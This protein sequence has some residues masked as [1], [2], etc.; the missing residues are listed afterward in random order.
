MMSR[1]QITIIGLGL[2]GGSLAKSLNKKKSSY[3]THAYARSASTLQKAEK[4]GDIT[5]G[6]TNIGEAVKQSDIIIFCTPLST[7]EQLLKEALPYLKEGVIITDA[8]SAKQS[9]IDILSPLLTKAQLKNFV[10]A[11]PIAGA[12]KSGYSAAKKTLF[13]DK[14]LFMTPAPTTTVA[15]MDEVRNLWKQAGANVDELPPKRHDAIYATVSHVPQLLAFAYGHALKALDEQTQY[16][17]KQNESKGYQRFRR[18]GDSSTAMWND[19]FAANQIAIGHALD[20]VLDALSLSVQH[21]DE[22]TQDFAR[23]HASLYVLEH[24][25]LIDEISPKAFVYLNVLPVMLSRALHSVAE[26]YLPY[27]GTG[28]ADFTAMHQIPL[29]PKE[30]ASLKK[31]ILEEVAILKE[32]LFSIGHSI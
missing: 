22:R 4:A 12:E 26:L 13:K 23:N 15:A 2:I 20:K 19:I 24:S 27:A 6:F 21:L 29:P 14:K 30:I 16:E 18:I 28:F 8:G 7:Y 9:V 31:H 17:I 3:I 11:H 1:K 25:A 10:P 32:T 5:K